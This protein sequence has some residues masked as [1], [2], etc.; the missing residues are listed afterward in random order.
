MF[1]VVLI[2]IIALFSAFLDSGAGKIVM[3]ASVIAIGLLLLRWIT[4]LTM[5]VTVAKGCAV[6]MVVVVVGILVLAIAGH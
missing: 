4:G 1:W 6:V 5:F 3:S 2:I